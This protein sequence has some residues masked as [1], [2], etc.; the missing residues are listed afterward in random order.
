MATITMGKSVTMHYILQLDNGEKIE[1]TYD[2]KPIKFQVGQRQILQSL[3]KGL[4]GLQSGD[5]K[6]IT[7]S[8]QEAY[9]AYNPQLVQIVDRATFTGDAPLSVGVFITVTLEKGQQMPCKVI[10]IT[11]DTVSLDFNHPAAG[12]NLIFNVEVLGVE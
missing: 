1:N 2:E 10:Q 3:E 9:G 5:Q 12:K 7:V 6:K 4:I 8:F 11:K